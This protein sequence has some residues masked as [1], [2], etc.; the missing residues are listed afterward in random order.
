MIIC[1]AV[2]IEKDGHQITFM[3]K[4]HCN[5]FETAWYAGLRRPWIEI[6][7]GFITDKFEF[8]NRKKARKHAID[9][10]QVK[11]ENL[12]FKELYSEDLW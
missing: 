5:C 2:K 11:E 8:L 4:R 12:E 6:S 9:C 7:Q 1:S 10:G 3:G